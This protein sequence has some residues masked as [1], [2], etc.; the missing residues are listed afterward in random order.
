[1]ILAQIDSYLQT[2]DNARLDAV[3]AAGARDPF[4]T[5]E[6]A[7][8]LED[9]GRDIDK[10]VRQKLVSPST[11]MRGYESEIRSVQNLFLG[12]TGWVATYRR[13]R[14]KFDVLNDLEKSF[15]FGL[16]EDDPRWNDAVERMKEKPSVIREAKARAEKVVMG[17]AARTVTGGGGTGYG[18]VYPD[19]SGYDYQSSGSNS[20]PSVSPVPSGGSGGM[21]MPVPQQGYNQSYSP[22]QVVFD[23]KELK[24]VEESF[25]EELAEEASDKLKERAARHSAYKGVVGSYQSSE[26]HLV[27]LREIYSYYSKAAQSDPIAQVHLALFLRYLGDFLPELSEEEKSPSRI[28]GLLRAA[29]QSD[30]AKAQ[31]AEIRKQLVAEGDF[32]KKRKRDEAFQAKYARLL[33]LEDEKLDMI[34]EVLVRISQ[35]QGAGGGGGAR[36]APAGAGG[37]GGMPMVP[38]G[39]GGRGRLGGG[40]AYQPYQPY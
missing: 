26:Y 28:E 32:E 36:G 12:E 9:L 2:A 38:G 3:R 23:E 8:K 20:Y 21:V 22:P 24:T 19:P 6:E 10:M 11:I 40:G 18:T 17:S 13:M 4:R 27:T 39:G 31:V 33:R 25:L 14:E 30:I 1:M 15:E 7:R 37:P 16:N 34:D 29:E 5:D 35:R